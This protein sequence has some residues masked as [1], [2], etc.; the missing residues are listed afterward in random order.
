MSVLLA[1]S[2]KNTHV[3]RVME[4]HM[5]SR[6][7]SHDQLLIIRREDRC[8]ISTSRYAQSKN[9]KRVARL[10]NDEGIIEGEKFCSDSGRTILTPPLP[11]SLDKFEAAF[12]FNKHRVQLF[13]L[14]AQWYRHQVNHGY[15]VSF[16]WFG[17]SFVEKIDTPADLDLILFLRDKPKVHQT[18]LYSNQESLEKFK[19]DFRIVSLSSHPVE[20]VHN[21]AQHALLLSNP[22]RL[23]KGDKIKTKKKAIL[24]MPASELTLV[25][26]RATPPTTR[27]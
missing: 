16:A 7:V 24:T 19:V 26:K 2:T 12:L 20:L 3:T 18:Q 8:I 1:D 4:R 27:L 21:V 9:D 25:K 23:V 5:R 22:S 15:V 10:F 11:I 14:F 13:D 17:G 6:L